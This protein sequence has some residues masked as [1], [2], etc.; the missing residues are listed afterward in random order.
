[1]KPHKIVRSAAFAGSAA[2]AGVLLTS[3]ARNDL[4]ESQA[5]AQPPAPIAVQ[6]T[7]P[8]IRNVSRL[9]SL[10]GEVHPWEETTLYAKVP[11]YLSKITVDK[12]D[13]VA[14]GQVIATIAAPELSAERDQARQVYRATVAAAQGSRAT[15]ERAGVE[16]E[17]SKTAAQK[18]AADYAQMPAAVAKARALVTQAQGAVRQALEQRSEAAATVEESKGQVK[19]A[20]ADL[21]A[22][23]SD[24]ELALL[25]FQRYRGIFDKNPML[26][27]RQDVDVAETRAAAA[28]NRTAAAQSAVDV[29]QHPVQA[30]KAKLNAADSLID[31]ARALETAAQEQVNVVLNQQNSARKQVD[32]ATEDVAIAVKQQSVT[33]AK[34]RETEFQAS[35]GR[36]A[37]GKAASL[38]DYTRIRAP[39]SG[40]VTRRFVDRGAFIQTAATSQ[41]AAPIATVANMDRVRLYLAVP[42]TQARFVQIGTGVKVTTA[43]L[44]DTVIKGRVSRTSAS[45]DPKTRTLLAEVDLPNQD[46][47]ILTGSYATARIV[48]ETHP[49]VTSVPTLAVGAEKA[50]KFVFVIVDGKAKRLPVTTGFDDGAYTE[51][52]EGLHGGEQVVVTGRDTLTPNAGVNATQWVPPTKK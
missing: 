5:H 11:G 17:R 25:T 6:T 21:E 24:R 51:I 18:A 13:R 30:A 26:I 20:E 39:F 27:A 10:P 22:A 2:M 34:T 38:A 23:K 12:G 28:R 42:E 1:M 47:T 9:I 33:R 40:I 32:I 14:G 48:M 8:E 19:K 45:L 49:G 7:K 35:A 41:N 36:T 50:G 29:A 43:G 16:H 4:A 52:V 37:S 3:C 44:P 31:Q 46:G 15:T